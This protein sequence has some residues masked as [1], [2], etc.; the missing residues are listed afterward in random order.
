M[1]IM[2]LESKVDLSC[3]IVKCLQD[4]VPD[5]LLD[6]EKSG[7]ILILWSNDFDAVKNYPEFLKDNCRVGIWF[8]GCSTLLE[9]KEWFLL[10]NKNIDT[11][12]YAP[13]GLDRNQSPKRKKV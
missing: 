8:A 4:V 6:L 2:S 12:W 13:A 11:S 3:Y 1:R 9:F 5:D 7:S 10:R